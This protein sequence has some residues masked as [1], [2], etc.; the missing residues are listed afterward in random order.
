MKNGNAQD[1]ARQDFEACGKTFQTSTMRKT[2]LYTMDWAN[3]HTIQSVEIGKW[4]VEPTHQSVFALMGNGIFMSDG[5][6]WSHARKTL[7]P[8][9]EKSQFED[10]ENKSFEAF[11]KNAEA[12]SEGWV[13]N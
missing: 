3:I 1:I 7:R 2:F 13:D 10:L 4:G 6:V 11:F 8:V 12:Y 9:F 5:P